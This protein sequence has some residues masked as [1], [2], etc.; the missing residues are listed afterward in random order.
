MVNDYCDIIFVI[1]SESDFEKELKDF[2]LDDLEKRL[3]LVVLMIRIENIE[4]SWM[5][6]LM[7]IVFVNLWKI[8]RMVLFFVV[9]DIDIYIIYDCLRVGISWVGLMYCLID[10]ISFLVE[11]EVFFYMLWK[12]FDLFLENFRM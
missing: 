9:Y 12:L 2:G 4:W 8:L 3:M 11:K 6:N 7:K 5:R 10:Y 1:V